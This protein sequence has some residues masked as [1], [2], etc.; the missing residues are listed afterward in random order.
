MYSTRARVAAAAAALL[1]FCASSVHATVAIDKSNCRTFDLG[2][3]PAD[4]TYNVWRAYSHVV[5]GVR[6]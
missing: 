3:F 5:R 6:A 1:F 4:L 2:T